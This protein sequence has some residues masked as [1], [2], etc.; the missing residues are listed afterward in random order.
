VNPDEVV[1]KGAAIQGGVLS[2]E[3][4]EVILL[5][6]TPLSLGIETLGGVMTKLIQRNTTIPTK[7]TQIFSTATDNQPAVSVHVMQGERE[8]AKDNRTLGRFDLV[9]IPPAPRGVPQI[10]VAFDIDANGIVNVSARDLGTGRTQEIAIKTASGLNESEIDRMVAEAEKFAGEDESKRQFSQVLNESEILLYSTEQTIKDFADKFTEGD[11]AEIK[12]AM[13]EVEDAKDSADR[14]LDALK[15][16][17]SKLQTLM[18]RFAELMYS[19]PDSGEF[20]D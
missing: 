3:V 6:V 10:E 7:K 14:D 17:T 16:A 8:M 18:H 12:Q 13:E 1:S 4:E 2:G 15:A 5:D 19:A 20:Q 9:G 11:I